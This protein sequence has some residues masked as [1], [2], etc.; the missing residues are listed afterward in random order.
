MVCRRNKKPAHLNKRQTSHN[1]EDP[2]Q[3]NR[4]K[5]KNQSNTTS[6]SPLAEADLKGISLY[7]LVPLE[8]HAIMLD[9]VG[10]V[11]GIHQ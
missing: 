2:A 6:P 10:W 5:K 3:Q 11:H 1:Q 9:T 4:K 8:M 7:F